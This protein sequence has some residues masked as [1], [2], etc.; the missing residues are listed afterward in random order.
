LKPVPFD[1]WRVFSVP[2]ACAG[3]AKDPAAV[4]MAGGQTLM[5][6][7][8]M[9]L[10]RPTTIIDI[11]RIPG[12]DGI[13]LDDQ[14]VTLGATMRQI[15]VER[16][17]AV[18]QELP[19][20][21]RAMPWVGHPPT[22]RRGTV[23]GSIANADATAEIGLVA[24][25]LGAEVL[26][27]GAG[28]ENSIPAESFFVGPMVTAL[29]QGAMVTGL[30]FA[31]RQ[32]RRLVGTGFAEIAQRHGDY[33][34]AAV[35]V[36]LRLDGSGRCREILLAV[37]GATTVPTRLEVGALIGSSL[38]GGEV[39]D[40]VAAALQKLEMMEDHN[41]SGTYRRRAAIALAVRAVADAVGEASA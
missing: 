16:S 8:A 27:A 35:A 41:T 6:M 20:L 37:G 34:M 15:D 24:V 17:H 7:L 38:A 1:Y 3:L 21:S 14:H 10:V 40:V 4:L 23:G 36:E 29:P 30:R 32:D 12:L 13:G 19:L 11:L 9:R 26:V 31:R 18:A 2:E 39:R 22:R 28:E 33:A 5:P 25:A